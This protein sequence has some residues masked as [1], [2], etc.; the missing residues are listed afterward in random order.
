[1]HWSKTILLKLLGTAK[2]ETLSPE[3]MQQLQT[4]FAPTYAYLEELGY[5]NIYQ[6][7]ADD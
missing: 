5:K 2:K 3:L 1:M 6:K 7:I 4:E